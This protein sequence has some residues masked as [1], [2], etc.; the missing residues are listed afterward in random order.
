ML[1]GKV[2]ALNAYNM[3]EEQSQDT[4]LSSCYKKLENEKPNKPK[5]SF[6]FSIFLKQKLRSVT[7]SPL[8][9]AQ[10]FLRGRTE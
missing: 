8:P 9:Q 10:H 7:N 3:K 1:R 5:A 6:S 4:N 2:I